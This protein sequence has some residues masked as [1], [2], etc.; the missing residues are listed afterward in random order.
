MKGTAL[1]STIVCF[2][3]IFNFKTI[4]THMPSL[5][6]FNIQSCMPEMPSS[7]VLLPTHY[8]NTPF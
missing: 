7:T 3:R 5:Q 8:V 6:L 1:L 4:V 2:I